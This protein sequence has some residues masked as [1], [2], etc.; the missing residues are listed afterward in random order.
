MYRVIFTFVIVMC[1]TFISLGLTQD[2]EP[3]YLLFASK[4]VKGLHNYHLLSTKQVKELEKKTLKWLVRLKQVKDKDVNNILP[5]DYL[6]IYTGIVHQT[7]RKREINTVAGLEISYVPDLEL[8]Y[9]IYLKYYEYYLKY[10]SDTPLP[11]VILGMLNRETHFLWIKGDY[12]HSIAPCQ[13]HKATAK[14]LLASNK[15]KKRFSELIYFDKTGNHHFRSQEAMVE[16]MYE[17]L[18]NTKKYAA[19]NEKEGI[20]AY[21]GS[22]PSQSYTQK[23]VSYTVRYLALR[24]I[25]TNATSPFPMKEK[26]LASSI[27]KML[28]SNLRT[29]ELQSLRFENSF[30][31]ASEYVE[32]SMGGFSSNGGNAIGEQDLIKVSAGRGKVLSPDIHYGMPYVIKD[33]N[34]YVFTYFRDKLDTT[35]FYHN[36]V[37]EEQLGIKP[38][39][40]Q[41]KLDTN[42]IYLFYEQVDKDG[43]VRHF[44]KSVD[45]YKTLAEKV[46]VKCNKELGKIYTIP[47]YP[48]YYEKLSDNSNIPPSF[49]VDSKLLKTELKKVN[50][51]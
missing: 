44:I 32:N 35:V 2:N 15:Y 39:Y 50:I 40:T 33:K 24:A 37:I 27:K 29:E 14:W 46:T 47:N 21:N 9:A 31:A 28:H 36:K 18:I 13:L 26:E 17:F 43:K 38:Y 20:A 1:M 7:Y 11:E 51:R 16:F 30:Q 6:N 12:G 5:S 41:S 45:E 49:Y 10:Q 25:A 42:F 23:V 4:Q 3:N 34:T 19:G 22:K 48:V 8:Y